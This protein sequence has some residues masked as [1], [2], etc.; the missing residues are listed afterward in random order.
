MSDRG[1]FL[2]A[3]EFLVRCAPS[4]PETQGFINR[5]T[6]AQLPDGAIVVNIARGDLV[7]DDALITALQSGRIA[8]AG[9]DV[10]NGE[11]A[12][13]DRRYFDLPKVFVVPHIGSAAR[14]ARTGMG[15]MLLD[16]FAALRAGEPVPNRVV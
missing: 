13:I 9:L 15:M 2:A 4:T 6:I 1:A 5:D 10:F 14:Q 8:A 12:N 3:S 16:G 7:D 11:P